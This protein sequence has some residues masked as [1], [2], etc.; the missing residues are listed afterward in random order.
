[1]MT[2]K[3]DISDPPILNNYQKDMLWLAYDEFDIIDS[4]S[5]SLVELG[6]LAAIATVEQEKDDKSCIEEGMEMES[7]IKW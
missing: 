4:N 5:R 1:M 7:K 2:D 6:F 3:I